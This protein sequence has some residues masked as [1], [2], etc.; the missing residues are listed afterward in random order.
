MRGASVMLEYEI[1]AVS[2]AVIHASAVHSTMS[3][4]CG[5]S[6]ARGSMYIAHYSQPVS[7]P[8][9]GN[10]GWRL[11][12]SRALA[13][14]AAALSLSDLVTLRPLL[15]LLFSPLLTPSLSPKRQP[16]CG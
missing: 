2:T 3:D 16:V 6:M 13:R 7:W 4:H 12:R 1:P 10:Y 14:E 5:T 8:R 15:S 11:S 9:G